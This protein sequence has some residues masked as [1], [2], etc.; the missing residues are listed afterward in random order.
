MVQGKQRVTNFYDVGD[1][2]VGDLTEQQVTDY[3]LSDTVT[4][5]NKLANGGADGATV[6]MGYYRQTAI[7]LKSSLLC[8]PSAACTK[9]HPEFTLAHELILHAYAGQSDDAI[10]GNAFYTQNG[11]WRPAGSTA[12]I[13]ISTW[14]G[15]DCT[16]TPGNPANP[17]NTCTANS[18]KW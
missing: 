17:P 7:V 13:N 14:M 16:C 10:F 18:A 12:T 5:A 9:S 2:G 11:L 4:L 15:T 3:Q 8:S 1:P 6:N